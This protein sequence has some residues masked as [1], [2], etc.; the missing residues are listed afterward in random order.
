MKISQIVANSKHGFARPNL[1][2]VEISK[3]R[4]DQQLHFQQN[5]FQAVIPGSNI[6]SSDKDIGMR[7]T[8]YQR[9][10]TDVILGFYCSGDMKELKYWQ[11]WID[12]IIDPTTNHVNLYN[13]YVGVVRIIQL[14][15]FQKDIAEWTL[16]D[17]YPKVVDPITLDYGA[18]DTITRVNVSLT[19]RHFTHRFLHWSGTKPPTKFSTP[20]IP[21]MRKTI[22]SIFV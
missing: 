11:E 19:Y 14:N 22:K 8:A 13:E 1:F 6:A 12:E 21:S 2:R 18:T 15:Q 9:L 17:A 3:I 10:F 5:C 4:A 7:G 20:Q 16:H